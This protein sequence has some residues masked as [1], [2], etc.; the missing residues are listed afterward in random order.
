M[1]STTATELSTQVYQVF[2]K[3][4][5]EAIWDA[6]IKPEFTTRYF[7]GGRVET[8]GEAGAPMRMFGP[9]GATWGDEIIQESDPPRRLVVGW[10]SLYDPE[11]AAEQRS[12]I[13][14]EIEPRDGGV[15]LVT[16]VHDQLE[17]SPL[18]AGR[19]S[20]EG[21]MGV[22]QR[23]QDAARDRPARCSERGVRGACW[24]CGS[25][26]TACAALVAL[27]V[28]AAGT[29]PAAT[30]RLAI[31]DCDDAARQR[32]AA[33]RHALRAAPRA[34]VGL[35]GQEA[36]ALRRR[37]LP[38]PDQAP[39]LHPGGRARVHDRGPADVAPAGGDGLGQPRRCAAR[40]RPR[41]ARP[42]LSRRRQAERVA[43]LPRGLLRRRV[44]RASR[45]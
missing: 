24:N 37:A 17:N 13:T 20:G 36:R 31:V 14:W 39:D 38:V 45:S 42:A 27:L 44:R 34:L 28:V 5:P 21:W 1:T 41:R 9:D 11:L 23:P 18:T 19:V 6:L 12:R 32:R 40:D 4:T 15:C 29:A 3:A 7:H 35:E 33:G 10:R 26:R 16:L 22:H 2:I 43:R 8:T 30:P 25:M